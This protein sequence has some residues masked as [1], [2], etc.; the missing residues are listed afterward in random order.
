MQ[1]V[2]M[3]YLGEV[4]KETNMTHVKE[5]CLVEMCARTLKVILN[6]EVARKILEHRDEIRALVFERR[7]WQKKRQ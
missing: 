4:A 7:L 5:I 3:R 1:G 2:N 6:T